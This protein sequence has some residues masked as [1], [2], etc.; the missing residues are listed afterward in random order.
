MLLKVPLNMAKQGH[1]D[2]H[3]FKSSS[4]F[5][6]KVVCKYDRTVC[7]H[8]LNQASFIFYLLQ[9]GLQYMNVLVL[10]FYFLFT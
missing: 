1:S 7:V 3:G 5:G 10:C 2:V 6:N 9:S 8:K 4:G